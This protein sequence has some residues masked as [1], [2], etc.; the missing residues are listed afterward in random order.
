MLRISD[1]ITIDKDIVSGTPVFKG[2][3]VPIQSLFDHLEKGIPIDEFLLDFP[4]VQKEQ[5]IALIEI[6]G[7]LLTSK[8]IEQLYEAAA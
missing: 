7:K 1:L 5:A 8:N 3:R 2:T 4:T 6:A